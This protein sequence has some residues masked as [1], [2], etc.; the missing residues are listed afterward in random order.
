MEQR[1]CYFFIDV[2]VPEDDRTMSVLC[3][4]CHDNKMP[5]TGWFYKGSVE[6]YGPY[7]YKCHICGLVIHSHEAEDCGNHD[8]QEK[9]TTSSS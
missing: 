4:P 6:G 2:S 3:I 1:D 8:D 5:D 7:T 9:E